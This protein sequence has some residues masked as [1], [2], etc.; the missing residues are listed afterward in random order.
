MKFDCIIMNPPYGKQCSTAK[1]VIKKIL[2]NKIA[3]KV[4][5]LTPPNIMQ[6]EEILKKCEDFSI[7]RNVNYFQGVIQPSLLITSF[8]EKDVNKYQ[9]EDIM[10]T[11]KEKILFRAIKNYN[12]N[13]KETIEYI[14]G[15][16][17][18]PKWNK[19][20]K[21]ISVRDFPEHLESIKNQTL[22]ES[23]DN[24]N[25]FVKT[26]WT[27]FDGVHF[28]EAHDFKYNLRNEYD[29]KWNEGGRHIDI[30]IFKDKEERDN[31]K[32]WWYSCNQ[33]RSSK[34]ERIGLTNRFLDL[35]RD[36]GH[37]GA[38][39]FSVYFPHLDWSRTWTDEEILE[40]IGLPRNFLE[41]ENEI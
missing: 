22:E 17:L 38:G 24:Q 16:F 6:D 18:K 25:A 29:L 32:D 30:Y 4:V 21:D 19:P 7:Y 23:V 20:I 15:S 9:I 13:H 14:D 34:K 8:S 37:G 36:S 26:L 1:P 31:Y 5:T 3:D 39:Y 28:N 12:S 40:E 35:V 27:P 10:F 11:E 33:K 41:T 2:K